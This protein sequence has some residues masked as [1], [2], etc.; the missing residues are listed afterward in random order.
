MA[1]KRVKLVEHESASIGCSECMKQRGWDPRH[2]MSFPTAEAL[3]AHL[4]EQW[5]GDSLPEKGLTSAQVIEDVVRWYVKKTAADPLRRKTAKPPALPVTS[6]KW[7]MME[8]ERLRL[9]SPENVER[10]AREHFAMVPD[11]VALVLRLWRRQL[12]WERER[13]SGP[14]PADSDAPHWTDR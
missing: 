11:Y 5:A 4:R 3:A 8:L 1:K 12:A 6:W 9:L 7:R 10:L 13:I 14:M 2:V